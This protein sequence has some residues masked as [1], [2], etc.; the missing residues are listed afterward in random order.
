M[1]RYRR[2]I[3]DMARV[4]IEAMDYANAL[5]ALAFDHIRDTFYAG[6]DP[7]D[8]DLNNLSYS[9][10]IVKFLEASENDEL[11]QFEAK[12][13]AQLATLQEQILQQAQQPQQGA[14]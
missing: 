14:Q 12:I 1:A 11:E 4:S 5:Q 3:G 8:M 6:D 13:G 7:Y 9:D 2:N 10:F